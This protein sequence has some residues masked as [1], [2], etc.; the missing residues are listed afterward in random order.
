MNSYFLM[1]LFA[2][3]LVLFYAVTLNS[4][5]VSI[6]FSTAGWLLILFLIFRGGHRFLYIVLSLLLFVDYLYFQNFGNLPSIRE[7]TLIPQVGDLGGDIKYFIDVYSL[8]FVAD[9]PFV[10]FLFKEREKS[11]SFLTLSLILISFTFIAA[12][13]TSQRLEPKFVFNRYGMFSYHLQDIIDLFSPQEKR[14]NKAEKVPVVEE[15]ENNLQKK[16]FGIGKGKNVIVVQMESLQNFVVGLTVNGQEITPNINAFLKDRDTIYF[17]RCYQQV[18]SGNTADAEFVVNTSLHTLGDAVVYEEYP[19]IGLPTLPKIMKSN[20]YHTIVFHGNVAWFWNREEVYKHI[21]FDEFVSLEDFKQD[22][23]F[24]MGLADVSFFKQ[25]VQKLKS[26][27]KP[28]YAFLITISSHTPFVIPEEHRKL[29]L[30]E[31][32]SDTIVGHYLQAIHYADE[33]FGVFLEEL[34]RTGLY[35][36]S[37]IVLYGDHAGLYPF[38]REVRVN[39]PKILG[40]EYTFEKALNVPFAIHIPG[41]G[42]HRIVKTTGGQI[43]FL[44]T[45]LN[46]MGIEYRE[47]FFMGRDLLNTSHGFVALRYHVPDGSFID[48]D[49][50]FIV[51]WDGRLDKSLAIENGEDRNYVEFL[52]GYVKAIQQIEASRYFILRNCKAISDFAKK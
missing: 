49:R 23:I 17:S 45:I 16:F 19:V 32:I 33:A 50:T 43:D 6:V 13:H 40:E 10:W 15:R 35:D 9:L 4:F 48:D 27:P 2:V 29:N 26:S 1:V 38:N 51:S 22:E 14:E 36:N 25:A 52:D 21:G 41:S 30:P 47:G 37:V 5:S 31:E 34:K 24:G 3:K 39:M 18:G 11:G 44:P 46:V 7:I 20:G 12:I 28:F 8:F 42:V